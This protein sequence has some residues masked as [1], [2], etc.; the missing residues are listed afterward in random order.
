M[1]NQTTGYQR[2]PLE[3]GPLVFGLVFLGVVAAWGLFELG[4][5]TAADTA[6]ILP[7]VLIGAGA[8]GVVLALTKPRRAEALQA[9]AAGY[10]ARQTPV[11]GTGW[12]ATDPA[13]RDDALGRTAA[14]APAH[15]TD[16]TADTGAAEAPTRPVGTD[17]DPHADTHS[18]P[19]T[20]PGHR[21]RHDD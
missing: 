10:A 14:G 15:A 7:I 17:T 20:D 21:E 3:I 2:H 18:R 12:S 8:L 9:A 16:D 4:V 6:W 13:V 5:V 11:T 1:N 19:D